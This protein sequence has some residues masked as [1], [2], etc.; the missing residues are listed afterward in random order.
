M[1]RLEILT[2][3][4][5]RLCRLGPRC[6]LHHLE[7][8]DPLFQILLPLLCLELMISQQLLSPFKHFLPEGE[9]LLL[10]GEIRRPLIQGGILF[11]EV[12][13]GQGDAGGPVIQLPLQPLQAL[14]NRGLLDPLLL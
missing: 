13:L 3:F 7:L 1:L 12:L 6:S 11:L 8:P 14:H 10:P 9:V 4:L 2:R 5:H